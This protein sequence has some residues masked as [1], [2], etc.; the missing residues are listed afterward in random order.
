[1]LK[2]KRGEA[3]SANSSHFSSQRRLSLAGRSPPVVRVRFAGCAELTARACL[4][5]RALPQAATGT[6]K[7]NEQ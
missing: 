3:G 5:Q 6:T 4:E 7:E 2:I 1:V